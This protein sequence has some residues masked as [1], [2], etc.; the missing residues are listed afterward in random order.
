MTI[1][2]YLFFGGKCEEAIGFYKEALGAVVEAVMHYKDHPEAAP[3]G[4]LAPDWEGKVMH[5][6]F[7][8]GDTVVMG[9]DGM[10]PAEP[11]FKGFSLTLNAKND[12]EADRLFSALAEGGEVRMPIG[13]TFFASR[14][15][16]VADRFGVPWMVTAGA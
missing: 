5:S 11:G 9:S 13:K 12:E 2:P 15:G 10:G 6:A 7:R 3:P 16:V 4:G 14:F 1:Q 8:I